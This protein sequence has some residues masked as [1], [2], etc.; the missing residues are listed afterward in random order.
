MREILAGAE[1]GERIVILQILIFAFVAIFA[2][3]ALNLFGYVAFRIILPVIGFLFGLWLGGDIVTAAFGGGFL[4]TSLGI[5]IGFFLGLILALISYFVVYLAIIIFGLAAGYLL[6]AGFM[7][8]L[9]FNDGV[10]TFMVGVSV[11]ALIGVAFLAFN[12]PRIYIMAI[13]AFAGA[14]A[15]IAGILALFGQIPPNQLG[16]SFVNAYINQSFF[17]VIVWV[18]VGV[19][20]LFIQLAFVEAVDEM[21][22]ESYS[23]ESTRKK[24]RRKR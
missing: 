14:S 5:I 24:N 20:G 16:L 9:G 4:A 15:M 17:W 11:A 12:L 21:M 22:P 18:V 3:I 10:F 8:L 2:G 7:L 1:G 6:G 23:Y 13:T 19:V